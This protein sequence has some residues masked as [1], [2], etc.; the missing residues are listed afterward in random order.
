MV[1]TSQLAVNSAADLRLTGEEFISWAELL[2]Q[3]TG[4][5]VPPERR[6]F[7]ESNLRRRMGELKLRSFAD[8]QRLIEGPSGALEWGTLVDR[9]T[10]HQTHFFRHLPSFELV[11]SEVLPAF[12]Q[13]QSGDFHAWSVG[14]STG[15]EAWSLAMV[16]D[17][18][19]DQQ[20][21]QNAD[22][23]TPS[24]RYG[25][26]GSDVSQPALN[27]ARAA[28]YQRSS[29][30]EVPK[31][32]RSRYCEQIDRGS[33]TISEKLKRRVQFVVL[34]LLNVEQKPLRD[35]DLIFCQN[36]LIYFPQHR[37]E[38]ILEQFAQC[39]RPGGYLILGPGETTT[40]AHPTLSRATDTR[41][42]AFRKVFATP[43]DPQPGDEQGDG[44]T[45]SQETAA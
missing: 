9:L 30:A 23:Q 6:T 22:S 44:P 27:K 40:W 7:L 18:F 31:G 10:V 26:T 5:V 12:S 4:V 17:H 41:A 20:T 24:F 36:V 19:A 8:F 39:L 15:E 45:T 16:I 35:L 13:R 1:G 3:R 34:N 29:L 38:H 33:F 25:I 28:V 43:T 21:A 42:L 32:F 11:R 37:R 2:A 14:A